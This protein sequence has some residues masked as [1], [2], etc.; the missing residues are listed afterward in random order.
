MLARW[1]SVRGLAALC[2]LLLV[3]SGVA[4]EAQSSYKIRSGDTLQIEVL[5]DPSLNRS[6]LVAPDGTISFPFVGSVQA[7]GRTVDSLG[8]AL[9]SGLEPNFAGR[10]NVIVAVGSLYEPRNVA[11]EPAKDPVIE[12][13]IMGEVAS[14]GKKEVA[15][16]TTILQIL[17]EAGGPTPFAATSRIQLH[18]TDPKTNSTRVYP[19]NFGGKTKGSSISPAT[20]LAP[21]DVVV[22]PQRRLFE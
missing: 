10:P 12:V 5:E 2:G 1:F 4:A 16:G 13:F 17:A 7:R 6:A 20:R 11:R 18:R 8:Q 22:V 21:G 14:A 19:F 9:A 15:P 3:V